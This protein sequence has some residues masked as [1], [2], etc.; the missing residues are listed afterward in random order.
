MGIRV[1]VSDGSEDAPGFAA[2]DD[3]IIASTYD[4]EGT[5]AAA[6]R[7]AQR[8]PIDGVICIASDVPLTVA[9]VAAALSLPGISVESAMLATDK[10][11]M[12][13]RFADDG[14]PIPSFFEVAS[15]DELAM[16]VSDH[17]LPLVLKPVDSR[18][19]RGVLL[20]RSGVDL[21]WAFEHSRGESPTGRVMAEAYLAGPQIS[22]ESIVIDGS[23]YTVGFADR[24][25]RELDR[26]APFI[27]ENGGELPSRLPF[28]QQEEVRALVQQATE[29]MGVIDGVVKGDIV[30]SDGRPYVIELALRLSGG[31]LCSHEIPLNTGVD[32]L[33]A[34]IRL[35]LGE[36]PAGH[37]LSATAAQGVAQRWLFPAPGTV[38]EISG[39]E[40]V[41]RRREIA[42]CEIRVGVGDTVKPVESHPGRAGVII[43]TGDTRDHAI[44]NAERAVQDI[45][46]VT[47]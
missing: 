1:V 14:V 42:L 3:H 36:R 18:G 8:H 31:Y 44:A 9:S 46:V 39:V 33:G 21:E 40:H 37:E 6:R 43:A 24:N 2:A 45:H 32:F 13:R 28:H 25:Y 35:A 4:I 5:V 15:A 29:S 47:A 30:Y 12:K 38:R 19:A 11:A 17:G 27:I 22:T 16:K 41:A 10:L 20:L 23:A 34:A 26:F 7:Y